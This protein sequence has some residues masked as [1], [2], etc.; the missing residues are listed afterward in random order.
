VTTETERPE[1]L[2]KTDVVPRVF[3]VGTGESGKTLL[4]KSIA[5]D[6]DRKGYFVTVY[7]P[8]LSDWGEA[9]F[10][11][12]DIM[13]F[14]EEMIRI[15]DAHEKQAIFIDEADG[16]LSIGDKQNHWLLTRGRHYV[17]A[18]YVIT[19]R[20]ALVSP[21]IRTQCNELYCFK[22]ARDDARKLSEDF[23]HDGITAAPELVQ[24]EYLHCY[25]HEKKKA[26]DKGKVF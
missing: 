2:K 20:P 26:L 23:A 22:V 14:M 10:V 12:D 5:A 25:W 7:D 15:H 18:I 16:A 8:M 9:A 1:G 17:N 13:L 4:A 19:Q 24:G 6:L 3:I 11:T 21:T